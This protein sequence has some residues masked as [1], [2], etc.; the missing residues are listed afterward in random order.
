MDLIDIIIFVGSLSLM[1]YLLGYPGVSN[2]VK[3]VVIIV[4]MWLVSK[5]YSR[6][7]LIQ[8]ELGMLMIRG[9]Y[10]IDFIDRMGRDYSHIFKLWA[11]TML[12]LSFGALV[13]PFMY[14]RPRLQ[15]IGLYLLSMAFLLLVM[16]IY[17]LA[18]SVVVSALGSSLPAQQATTSSSFTTIFIIFI[19]LFV[20]GFGGS[21]LVS[22]YAAAINVIYNLYALFVLG[23]K[24]IMASG[25]SLIL[26]GINIP[27]LE[28]TI[29]LIILLL[30]HEISHGFL[31]R[32]ERISLNSTGI[33]L[34]GSLPVGA[35]VEPSDKELE[36]ASPMIKSRILVAGS[37]ANITCGFIFG[38][39]YL[40]VFYYGF[41]NFSHICF[42]QSQASNGAISLVESKTCDNVLLPF[43]K[44]D[45]PYISFLLSVL[46]LTAG[47]N[48]AIGMINLI[49][50][51]LFDGHH[52]LRAFVHN[53]EIV[54][55]I[56]Y[57]T[58]A[59]FILLII[60]GFL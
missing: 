22:L 20:L 34:F 47:L 6:K 19:P 59:C 24:V 31:S 10:F 9:K 30:V 13:L 12:F 26:P 28:G 45:N 48:F 17:P 1:Y 25:I 41:L 55:F 7:Y 4:E 8:S 44:F 33:V 58:L 36:R 50:I 39:L 14:W 15:R 11:D 42:A 5:Y 23:E 43:M 29:S 18:I 21:A 46:G 56:S 35:F 54:D 38:I 2:I 16:L 37:A 49:P 53:K 32:S 3:T 60:P 27:F 40:L 52:I 57:A 51:P